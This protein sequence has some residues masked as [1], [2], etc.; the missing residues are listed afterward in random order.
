VSPSL[1]IV[2]F[3]VPYPPDYGGVTDVY[4]KLYWLHQAGVKIVLHCFTY[5]RPPRKELEELCMK[6]YYYPRR[7]GVVS[8]LS[9]LPYTV[10]SRISRELLGNLTADEAPVLFEVLHTCYFM[11]DKRLAGRK[12]IY[13]HSNIEHDYYRMLARS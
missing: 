6:V 5:G 9:L 1:H 7:T 4:W 2:S 8:N 3:D 13:R 10:R 11:Q 12:R